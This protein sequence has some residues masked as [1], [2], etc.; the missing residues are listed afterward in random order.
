[1]PD[2]SCSQGARWGPSWASGLPKY[3]QPCS[4]AAK[5]QFREAHTS[6]SNKYMF[7]NSAHA[8]DLHTSS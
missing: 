3:C 2:T 4:V 1:M 5:P 7:T 6:H 8:A